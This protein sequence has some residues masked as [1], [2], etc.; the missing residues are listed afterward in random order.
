[1]VIFTFIL[2]LQKVN[3]DY[4]LAFDISVVLGGKRVPSPWNLCAQVIF[5]QCID[6]RSSQ[7]DDFF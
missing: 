4:G 7:K 5:L 6:H 2:L 3:H 1:M